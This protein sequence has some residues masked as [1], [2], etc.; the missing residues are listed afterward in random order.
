MRVRYLINFIVISLHFLQGIGILCAGI[1]AATHSYASTSSVI[2]T[3]TQ[4]RAQITT[5][6]VLLVDRQQVDDSVGIPFSTNDVEDFSNQLQLAIQTHG[7]ERF[8]GGTFYVLGIQM[9]DGSKVADA[10]Q[11]V[12]IQTGLNLV[13]AQIKVLSV[14]AGLLEKESVNLAQDVLERMKYFWPSITRDYQKPQM[15]EVHAGWAS[16][17]LLEIPT[18]I[19]LYST[20][21]TTDATLT[22][23]AHAVTLGAYAIYCKTM[24]NWLLRPSTKN[25]AYANLELFFKQMLVS[26]PFMVNYNIFGHFTEISNYYATNGWLATMNAFPG[27]LASFGTTQGLTLLLQTIFYS[28][29]I[30]KGFGSWVNRQVGD[31]NSRVA[32]A[33]RPW[34]QT[35]VLVL[36]A[37]VF[38]MASSNWGQPIFTLGPAEFNIGHASLLALTATSAFML[39]RF[40]NLLNFGIP[41][42]QSLERIFGRA[43]QWLFEPSRTFKSKLYT[44]RSDKTTEQ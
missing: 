11:E 28:Q 37:V 20:L 27:E 33:A 26:A 41:V 35:P 31:E 21:P 3:R 43:K 30:S 10:Y 5:C 6:Q 32:R 12:L 40:P 14:P 8:R 24:L 13:G 44:S 39:T 15:A 25:A 34:L 4:I 36:D 19:F 2:Q 42:Y 23:L 7:A 17:A 29:V 9:Q 22:A 16:T 1:L 18:V 38:A